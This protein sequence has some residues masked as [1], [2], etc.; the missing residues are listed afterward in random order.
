MS[1]RS[2]VSARTALGSA[3]FAAV[4][5]FS[6]IAQ[7]QSKGPFS[8]LAGKWSGFGT[9]TLSGDSE[10]RI[11]CRANYDVGAG[12]GSLRLQLRCASDSYKFELR[13]NVFYRN[14]A[15]Q[16]D[17]N[18]ATR[19]VAGRVEGSI[20]GNRF[21]LRVDSQS[22]AALLSLITSGSQQSITIQGPPGAEMTRAAISLSRGS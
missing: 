3:A 14:G 5:I 11:R 19:G 13:S 12:G 6:A 4:I 8:T 20:K 10:E 7:G 9:L 22:F 1:L 2:K 21:D 18:E 16:G 15:V 17:W